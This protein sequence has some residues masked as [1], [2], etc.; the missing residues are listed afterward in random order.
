MDLEGLRELFQHM[1]WADAVVWAAALPQPAAADDLA[2]RG[3][4]F[5]TH[6]VQQAFLSVWQAAPLTSPP[7]D[8]PALAT[9]LE[10][11]RGY[12]T[13][14]TSFLSA[15]GEEELGRPVVLPWAAGFARSLGREPAAPTMAE[16]MLQ[17]AM[18]STYHRGQVN[19]RLRE[20]GIGPP[21]TDYIAWLWFGRPAP[22][23]PA[24]S[25]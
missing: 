21:L 11:A 4:L 17:V 5:H 20:L 2:L 24:F 19:A 6:M 9:T 25:T 14:L 3:K 1:Q 7:P 18:H 23:W 13:E 8:P 10:S 12:Y 16:T 15:L 22:E